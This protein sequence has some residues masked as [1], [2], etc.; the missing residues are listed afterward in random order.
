MREVLPAL[1][2]ILQKERLDMHEWV[3]V[4]PAIQEYGLSRGMRKHTVPR[5][6]RAGAAD[7]FL[8]RGFV[9]RKRLESGCTR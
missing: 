4:V 7:K 5:H 3:D 6:V 9:D 8:N 1:R 2:A